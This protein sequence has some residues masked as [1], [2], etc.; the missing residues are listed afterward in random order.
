MAGERAGPR[1]CTTFT[2]SLF[3]PKAFAR[4][5]DYR[6][7][8]SLVNR[9]FLYSTVAAPQALGRHVDDIVLER[10]EGLGGRETQCRWTTGRSTCRWVNQP[11]LNV[12]FGG[13]THGDI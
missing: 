12:R 6:S 13:G 4:R 8:P 11:I 7:C 5:H 1:W 2:I 9:R 3:T 10:G